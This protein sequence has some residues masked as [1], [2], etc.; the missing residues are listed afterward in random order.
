MRNIKSYAL[1]YDEDI[2]RQ[3]QHIPLK[4]HSLIENEIKTQLT[5]QPNVTSKNRKSLRIPNILFATW[6][7]RTGN[8]NEYRIFYTINE[9]LSE[10]QILAIGTKVKNALSIGGEEVIL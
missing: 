8:K 9:N 5:Y 10:V 6:E 1:V 4:H 2:Q 3:L 7:L